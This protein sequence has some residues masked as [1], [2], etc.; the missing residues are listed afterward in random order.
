MEELRSCP[1]CG[2]VARACQQSTYWIQCDTCSAEGGGALTPEEA[3]ANWN[4]RAGDAEAIAALIE[5]TRELHKW[6]EEYQ[7]DLEQIGA[8]APLRH[9]SF[10]DWFDWMHNHIAT[11][12]QATI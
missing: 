4:T 9:G 11:L 12:D 6:L 3:V 8:S 1:F 5:D 10:R 2:G 7:Y